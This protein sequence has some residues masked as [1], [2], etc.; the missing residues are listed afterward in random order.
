MSTFQMDGSSEGMRS[1]VDNCNKILDGKKK[2]E[3]F[4]CGRVDPSEPIESTVEGLSQLVKEG[5]IGGIQ[6]SEVRAET[7]RRAAK[8]HKIE[9]VEAEVL[10]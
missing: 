10:L 9:V 6:L 7:I 8:I 3:V 5:R 2:I 1:I 4:G